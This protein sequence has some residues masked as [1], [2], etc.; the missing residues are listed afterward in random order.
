M[1]GWIFGLS[2]LALTALALAMPRHSS[3]VFRRLPSGRSGRGFRFAGWSFL[4]ISLAATWWRWDEGVSLVFWTASLALHGFA[5]ALVLAY[6]PRWITAWAGGCV[7]IAVIAAV[8]A[9]SSAP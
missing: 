1:N 8:T 3:R 5:L 9:L 2:G 4:V 7:L 6:R